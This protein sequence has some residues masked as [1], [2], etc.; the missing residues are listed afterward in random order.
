MHARMSDPDYSD[1][2]IDHFEHPRHIGS[3]APGVDVIAGAGG[4]R[5][6]GAV[7]NLTARIAV[8][9]VESVRF[10]VYGCPHCVAAGSWLSDRLVGCSEADLERWSWREVADALQVPLE[11]RGK[12]LLLED[13][14]RAMAADWKGR[15]S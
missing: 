6:R 8:S 15:Q 3:F 4:T 13:A 9:A 7:F 14:V 1:T 2:V 12:L 10:E 11:K 5:E